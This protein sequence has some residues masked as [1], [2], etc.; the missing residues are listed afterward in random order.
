MTT[1]CKLSLIN[2][3]APPVRV[4]VKDGEAHVVVPEGVI[5]SKSASLCQYTACSQSVASGRKGRLKY[6]Q[7][8]IEYARQ[9]TRAWYAE[10]KKTSESQN[11]CFKSGCN[12]ARAVSRKRHDLKGRFCEVHAEHIRQQKRALKSFKAHQQ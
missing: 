2:G 9:N 7:G 12:E 3:E 6:C 1:V 4:E 8:H 10:R 11:T 5:I